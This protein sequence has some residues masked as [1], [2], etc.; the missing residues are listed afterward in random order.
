LPGDPID[1]LA[2]EWSH[3][4]WLVERW[5]RELGVNAA[6]A[7]VEANTQA[8]RVAIRP[9][10]RRT[11][12][13]ALRSTLAAAGIEAR[14]SDVVDGALVVEARAASLRGLAAWRD[15]LFA[16]QGEASQL[17]AALV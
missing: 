7:L 5:V 1:R 2:I 14:P 15:G 9:N 12:S 16:F 6:A 3:P 10:R 17:V 11:T 4:R 8:P 13:D